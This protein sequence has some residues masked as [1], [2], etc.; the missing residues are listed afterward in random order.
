MLEVLNQLYDA[1]TDNYL[2]VGDLTS[3][4]M[5]KL[6]RASSTNKRVYSAEE[7][8]VGGEAAIARVKAALNWRDEP[9]EAA[10]ME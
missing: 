3:Y 2:A 4:R 1:K 10:W 5:C 7:L 8:A 9:T 6:V